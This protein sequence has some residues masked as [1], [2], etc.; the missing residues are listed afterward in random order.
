MR[1]SR[2]RR[3][4][5]SIITGVVLGLGVMLTT[6]TIKV[7]AADEAGQYVC[8]HAAPGGC[9]L[10]QCVDAKCHYTANQNGA[11]CSSAPACDWVK[12]LD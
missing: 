9:S 8:N 12:W 11:N 4:L 7:R 10:E 6:N 1:N 3:A 5:L 2:F